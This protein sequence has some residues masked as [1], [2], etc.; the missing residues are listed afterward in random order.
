M[1]DEG[2][3][4]EQRR[5]G[6]SAKANRRLQEMR[7]SGHACQYARIMETR[8]QAC[9]GEHRHEERADEDLRDAIKFGRFPRH[10]DRDGD[11]RG[12]EK[13]EIDANA[14]KSDTLR[15]KTTKATCRR[16]AEGGSSMN[17]SVVEFHRDGSRRSVV[18]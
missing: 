8:Q 17:G 18:P 4:D 6:R 16:T 13:R 15:R 10:P 5:S 12:H 7:D 9:A 11:D 3:T 2:S 14:E 1:P